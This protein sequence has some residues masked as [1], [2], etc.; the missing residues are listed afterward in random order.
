MVGHTTACARSWGLEAPE[1]EG[2]MSK[3]TALAALPDHDTMVTN[4]VATYR[5]AD[6]DQLQSGHSWYSVARTFAYGLSDRYEL[7]REQAAGIIAALSPQTSWEINQRNADLFAK[8]GTCPT[9]G[10][11]VRNA[12]R[13][14]AG[15]SWR[16]VLRGPKTRAFAANIEGDVWHAVTVDRHAAR[17]AGF[18]G[19]LGDITSVYTQ[20]AD[21]YRASASEVSDTL[22]LVPAA[23]VQ[24]TTWIVQRGSA[25]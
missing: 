23:F 11:S 14:A 7:T 24:A 20:I 17:V 9:L 4:I 22:A 16:D 19:E 8:T 3:A 13:I 21:A 6:A 1:G 15:E 5:R 25:E 12:Q 10:A 18:T 2:I